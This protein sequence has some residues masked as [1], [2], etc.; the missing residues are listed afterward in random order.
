[1]KRLLAL[2]ALLLLPFVGCASGVGRGGAAKP[3]APGRAPYDERQP[4]VHSLRVSVDPSTARQILESLSRPRYEAADVKVLEDSLAVRL[5]IADSGRS[6][7]VFERDFAAAFQEDNQTAVFDFARIRRERERWVALLDAVAARRSELERLSADRAASILPADRPVSVELPVFLSFGLAGLADHLVARDSGRPAVI[8]DLARA[9]GES[10]GEAPENQIGRLSRLLAGETF[11]EAWASYRRGSPSWR[12][13]AASRLGTLEPLV[14]S[15]AEAGPVA[16]FS[17]EE[18]FFPLSTW[19]KEPMNKSVSDLNRMAERLVESEKDLEARVALAAELKRPDFVVRTGGPAGAFMA[20]GI[21]QA[22]G[23]ESLRA[24]LRDGPI[25][26]FTAYE[27]AS[28]ARDLPPLAKPLQE[29]I[30]A[31]P[32]R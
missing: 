9:L 13:G 28:R 10:E 16:L 30:S 24:A 2:L 26:F 6:R 11:R 17:I 20:D 21:V 7:E 31:P 15:V 19:L 23:I 14:R 32:T 1:M 4:G 27:R 12:P 22:F 25:A 5:A 3:A 29:R 18:S 8:V